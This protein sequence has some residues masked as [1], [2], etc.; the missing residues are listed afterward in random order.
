VRLD[1]DDPYHAW[2]LSL[3]EPGT[4]TADG[5]RYVAMA[6]GKTVPRPYHYRWLMPR[7]LGADTRTWA[8]ASAAAIVAMVPAMRW[9]TGKWSPGLFALPLEGVGGM[10]RS[11]PVVVDPFAMLAAIVAAAATRHRN[12]PV[13]VAASALTTMDTAASCAV[14]VAVA[15]SADAMT[16]GTVDTAAS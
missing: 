13:A 14:A 5:W 1:P 4:V 10:A 7:L 8:A 6:Q 9:L 15:A 3:V 16:A 12:L 2:L 11:Y